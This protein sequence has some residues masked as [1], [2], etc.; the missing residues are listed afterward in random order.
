MLMTVKSHVPDMSIGETL[1]T[2]AVTR[3]TE[4]IAIQDDLGYIEN[5]DYSTVGHLVIE[6]LH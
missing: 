6:L 4:Y 1:R 5:P 3:S 2:L